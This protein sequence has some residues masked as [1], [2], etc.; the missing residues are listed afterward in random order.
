MAEC[1]ISEFF[2]NGLLK[3]EKKAPIKSNK[4]KNKAVCKICG[5]VLS[6]GTEKPKLQTTTGLKLHLKCKHQNEFCKFTQIFTY[7]CTFGF[8]F[9]IRPKARCFSGQIFGFGLK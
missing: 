6:L 5:G 8:G 1:Q 7:I 9:G 4:E 3:S 2:L